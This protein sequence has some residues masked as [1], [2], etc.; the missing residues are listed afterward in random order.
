MPDDDKTQDLEKDITHLLEAADDG[1]DGALEALM[2]RVYADLERMARSHL[3]RQFGE[4]AGAITLEPAA[5]VNESFMKLIRQRN[6]YDNRGHFF[7]IATRVM[8]RVLIDYRRQRNA[9]KRGGK[10]TRVTLLLDENLLAG[11][12]VE[13]TSSIEVEELAAALERLDDLS[14]RKADV[15]RMRVVWGLELGEVA[16]SLDVSLSTVERDWRFAKAWLAEEAAGSQAK[17]QLP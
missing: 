11:S 10:E 14:P 8:L 15:V 12:T 7:S 6:R 16:A 9:L 5:L 4:R 17:D 1:K 3:R 13:R 2:E